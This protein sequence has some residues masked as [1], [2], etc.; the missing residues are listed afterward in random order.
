MQMSRFKSRPTPAKEINM[1]DVDYSR[2]TAPP[3]YKCGKCKIT[4]VKLWREYQTFRP[5]LFCVHCAEKDQDKHL[6]IGCDQ[7]GWLVPAVP[8]EEGVGYWGYTSVPQEGVRW[9]K[10]LPIEKKNR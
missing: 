4:G 3:N 2:D 9:W 5:S 10:S 8:D 6:N 7:I 1:K